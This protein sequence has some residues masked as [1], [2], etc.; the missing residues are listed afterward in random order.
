[1]GSACSRGATR[2]QAAAG[3]IARL[4]AAFPRKHNSADDFSLES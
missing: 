1:M 2:D 3:S 4:H